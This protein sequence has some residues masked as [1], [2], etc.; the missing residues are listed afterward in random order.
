[1]SLKSDCP[2]WTRFK[3]DTSPESSRTLKALRIETAIRSGLAGLMKKSTAPP[4]I[5]F[6]TG[7]GDRVD[8]QLTELDVNGELAA[9]AFE[10]SYPEDAKVVRGFSELTLPGFSDGEAAAGEL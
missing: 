9:G 1:M 2:D 4:R 8:L 7:D 5:A 3:R 10:L 6:T